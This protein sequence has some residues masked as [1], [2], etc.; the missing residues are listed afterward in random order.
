VFGL[1]K[2]TLTGILDR[3][4]RRGCVRRRPHPSDRRSFLVHITRSGRAFAEKVQVP[5]DRLEEEIA[6]RVGPRDVEGF[7]RVMAAIDRVTEVELRENRPTRTPK[8]RP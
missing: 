5:V 2:S 1:K 7:R 3:L 4:E 6:D 8:E